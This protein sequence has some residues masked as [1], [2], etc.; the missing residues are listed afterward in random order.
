GACATLASRTMSTTWSSYYTVAVSP[1]A[2]S[3][4]AFLERHAALLPA[5]PKHAATHPPG[6]VLY[7]RGL[8]ALFARSPALTRAF[9]GL[10]GQDDSQEPRPP[11]TRASRAAALFG[12]LL[13][14]FLGVAA[15]WPV[16]SI[17]SRLSGDA[18][19]GARA[20][21]LW[22]LVPGAVLFIPQFD[23]AMAFAI[24]CA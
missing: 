23:Q 22:T 16:A 7:Y 6:P 21:M 9:L 2:A 11:N 18:L 10:Q 3:P 24:A 14:T 4:R 20:G 17:A 1:E 12:A 19:A 5:L 13:L 8:V 15:A